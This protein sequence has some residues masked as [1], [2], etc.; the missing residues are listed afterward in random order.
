MQ[1]F[2]SNASAPTLLA[3]TPYNQLVMFNAADPSA[4]TV[5]PVVG[6]NGTLLGIDTR[7]ATGEVYAL[8]TAN[9]LYTLDPMGFQSG[10][11]NGLF[12]LTDEEVTT[13]L[14][15]NFYVNLHNEAF[16]GG[17][18]RGQVEV[19]LEND[20]VARGIVLEEAQEVGGL[21]PDGPATGTFDVIYDD[22]TNRLVI[23][24][25]FAD[26]TTELFP[27]GPVDAEGNPQSSIHLHS[28]VAGANG[29]IIRNFTVD[30]TGSFA[31]DFILTDEEE[32]LLLNDGL[33]VN[34][35]TAGSNGGEL[36]GQVNVDVEG[37]IVASGIAIEEAQQVGTVV[38][39]G[40]ATGEFGVVFDASTQELAIAGTFDGLTAPLFP[41]GGADGAGN[42]ES[43]VH[44]HQGAAGANGPIIRNFTATDDVAQLVSTLSVPFEAG[45]ISGFDFNPVPDRLRLTGV[46]GQNFRINV[47]TGDVIVDGTLAFVPTD[48]NAGLN[49]NVTASAY[50]NAIAGTTTT[51]LFNIDAAL[52]RL[53]L[54]AP[55]NDGGLQTIGELGFDF[56]NLG[57]FD[58]FSPAVGDNTAY[59]VSDAMLYTVDLTT[60]AATS[61]G[62]IGDDADAIFQGL[63][64]L[65]GT[66]EMVEPV[67]ELIDLTGFDGDVTLSVTVSREA[68]FNNV[69]RFYETD[70]LG[71]VAGLMPGDAGYE[72]AIAANLLDGAELAVANNTTADF[73]LTFSGG[74]YYAPVLLLDGSLTNLASIGDAAL[75]QS[76]V[77]RTGDVFRFEDLTDFDFN[78][79][80]VTVNAV[81]A[82]VA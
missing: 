72:A 14:A 59:L 76:R 71:T 50:T 47:E 80:V 40:P 52:D 73:T 38:P 9:E 82:A 31:G 41:I 61:L 79:L 56:D 39:D 33:Y 10:S 68:L 46:N 19:A 65:P 58:I 4:T 45:A 55:P 75:G 25:A 62:M 42:P 53:L 29:P 32:A 7:P 28:G 34:I 30:P 24:G 5:I 64:V 23:S 20:I 63:T 54:Q 17:E 43:A 21:V 1:Q 12:T 81:E 74:A 48:V 6:I 51:Q 26:L 16:N 36:R 49:P 11:F 3:L 15:G 78:D 77:Q 8:T 13:L 27:V 2:S 18:L 66:P 37:D 57:G 35:H 67:A 70:A 22:A 60:G 69:L 44:L